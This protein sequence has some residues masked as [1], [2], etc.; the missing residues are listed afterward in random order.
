MKIHP[1]E[2]MKILLHDLKTGVLTMHEFQCAC[3]YWLLEDECWQDLRP[4]RLPKKPD[5][6]YQWQNMSDEEKE[7][8]REK[9]FKRHPEAEWWFGKCRCIQH[10]NLSRIKQLRFFKRHLPQEDE[11]SR[12]K[13]IA[14]IKQFIRQI[15]ENRAY[16]KQ[17]IPEDAKGIAEVFEGDAEF[18]K[19]I[20]EE[21]GEG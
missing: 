21:I 10:T 8:A 19:K 4:L 18:I 15:R 13:C 20:K 11:P 6:V 5:S 7:T 17:K 14:K 16:R 12:R 1:A 3:A 2:R 9:F